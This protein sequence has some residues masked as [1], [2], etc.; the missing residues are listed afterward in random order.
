MTIQHRFAVVLTFLAL[1]QLPGAVTAAELSANDWPQFRRDAGRTGDN[2]TATLSFPLKRTTAMRFPAPIYASP[3]VAD[4][5]VYIQDARGNLACIDPTRN[6]TLWVTSLGGINNTSSP[7][8]ADGKVFVGNAANTLFILDAG[9]GKV[10]SKVQAD[11]GVLTAP[12]VANQAVYFSTFSGKLVKMDFAGKVQ[13]TFDGGRMSSTEFAIRDKD[14]LFFAG[15]KTTYLYRLRDEGTQVKVVQKTAAP[16]NCCPTAGPVFVTENSFAFQSFDSESGRFYLMKDD[17]KPV[18]A[19][20]ISDSRSVPAVR[21]DLIYR[22]DKCYEAATLKQVWRADPQVLYDGGFHSSPALAKDVLVVGCEQGLVHVFDLKGTKVQKPRWQYKTERAGQ[23]DSAVSS[24]PAVVDGKIF[25]GGEDGILYG[26]GQG[27]EVAVADVPVA[28]KEPTK[29]PVLKGS[30]WPTPGGDMG[31]SCV[32]TDRAVKPPYQIEWQTRLWSVFKAPMIVADGRVYCGGRLGNFTALDAATGEILWKIHHPGVESR[33]APTYV[34]GKLLIMRIRNG[35]GDSPYVSGASGGPAGEGLWCH[36]A[37]TGKVLWHQPM[38]F[39]YHYNH[40]GVVVH[41]GKVF[42][43]QLDPKKQIQAVAFA[44]D[45]GKEVWRQTLEGLEAPKG[46]LPPRFS[47]VIAGGLWCVSVSDQGTL[48]LDPGTGKTVWSTKE[49]S[50]TLRARVA[51]RDGVLVVF[52]EAG[53]HALDARTGKLLW[54]GGAASTRYCQ[55]LTDRYMNS[56]GQQGIFPPAVCAWPIYA[57]G[58]WYS[59][60]SFS[61]T[62][63]SN[64]LSAIREP[65]ENEGAIL[66]DKMVVWSHEFTCNACPS[67]TPAYGRLYYSPNSEGVVY[68]F[69]P[70]KDKD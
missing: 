5:K 55:A 46:K 38:A 50:I 25:F 66:T 15:T 70:K 16:A 13:W 51:G 65:E 20:D 10:L 37:R 11:G 6:K 56:K 18:V 9:T 62:H 40:D 69:S 28:V 23:P 34:D 60:R 57:N 42:V 59:H 63:G 3:A 2:P 68:C 64:Q 53:D 22:G 7:A 14:I 21:G 33:P 12:A 58:Y 29:R 31:F 54:K 17:A 1:I 32:S 30:E 44:V 4:G 52:N 43:A 36:D 47:G 41:E 8:V 35:Q 19:G 24:S 48:G 61:T 39:R 27:T 49:L 45:T 67:P 26:L